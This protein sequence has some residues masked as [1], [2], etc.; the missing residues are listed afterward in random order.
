MQLCLVCEGPLIN[1]SETCCPDCLVEMF[2]E[3]ELGASLH[4]IAQLG[5]VYMK[6]VRELTPDILKKL[7]DELEDLPDDACY[8]V[9]NQ[10]ITVP[11]YC[12]GVIVWSHD[13]G[14]HQVRFVLRDDPV[15][16]YIRGY[17]H[18]YVEKDVDDFENVWTLGGDCMYSSVGEST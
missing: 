2:S 7:H 6:E 13:E 15:T 12:Q 16:C 17:T 1:T 5:V 18:K 8:W 11:K 3:M 9:D 4:T 14:E 10:A